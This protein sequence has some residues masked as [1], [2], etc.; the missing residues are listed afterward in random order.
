M[1]GNLGGT[2]SEIWMQLMPAKQEGHSERPH[3]DNRKRYQNERQN[4]QGLDYRLEHI[5]L[6]VGGGVT[7]PRVFPARA[8][9]S[10]LG[11]LGGD[12]YVTCW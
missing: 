7:I 1:L 4:E 3:D 6:L 12:V 9:D 8:L 5:W 2:V 10:V 11:S